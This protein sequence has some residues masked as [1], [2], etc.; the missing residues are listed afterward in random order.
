MVELEGEILSL[1]T[2]ERLSKS[3]KVLLRAERAKNL[4]ELQLNS[5]KKKYDK[6][7]QEVE[8]LRKRDETLTALENSIPQWINNLKKSNAPILVIKEI[9]RLHDMLAEEKEKIFE[10]REAED[11]EKL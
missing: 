7:I 10:Y 5:F 6:L 1:D 3:E 8:Y 11:E 4:A 2:V 9:E